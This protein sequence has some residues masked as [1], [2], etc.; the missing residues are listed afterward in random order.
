MD[1][2]ASSLRKLVQ[3]KTEYDVPQQGS[4]QVFLQ[5]KQ[6]ARQPA[7]QGVDSQGGSSQP[8]FYWMKPQQ[9]LSSNEAGRKPMVYSGNPVGAAAQQIRVQPVIQQTAQP[10]PVNVPKPS[11]P[12][13]A[14]PLT[15]PV[16]VRNGQGTERKSF[17]NAVHENGARIVAITSGKGGV[18][19]TNLTVN[20]AIA[21]R[22]EG[23]RVIVIDADFGMANVD[24]VLGTVSKYH[25][26]HLLQPEITLNDVIMH[27]PYGVDYISGGS[28]IER[29]VEFTRAERQV[30]LEKLSAC[31][32]LA[33][34]ILI[35]TGAG[36]GQNVIEFIL[37][38][39]E[40][41]LVTTPEPTALTDAY[42]VM[43]AYNTH[44][45]VKNMK[46]VVNRIY[47]E[48]EG[49]DVTA[50]LRRTAERFLSMRLPSL[51]YIYEDR[52]VM[53]A[54]KK[55]APLLA[56]Y[57]NTLAARCVHAI[58]QGILYGGRKSVNLGWRGFLQK[59]LKFNGK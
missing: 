13:V 1:D 40:V 54:V 33:D 27:G 5:P 49:Q 46:L 45:Q 58:A 39:D 57:P 25:L 36:L 47:D 3:D 8:P 53:N 19:K 42:A 31:G 14:A 4:G 55:Q 52:N 35:D 9:N 44:A 28:A 18:G 20:L 2:Q 38:A 26:M 41:V 56:V 11:V 10:S 21:M 43:K 29:A 48:R 50:K 32:E 22:M 6:P 24:V 30:L 51:G 16:Q 17:Q 23:K 37:A 12:Y 7:S 15:Q 59:L 34:V